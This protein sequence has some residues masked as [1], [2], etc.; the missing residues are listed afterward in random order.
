MLLFFFVFII[1]IIFIIIIVR[2][3]MESNVTEREFLEQLHE[4]NQ[5]IRLLLLLLFLLRFHYCYFST[6]SAIYKL[7]FKNYCYYLNFNIEDSH[8][9]FYLYNPHNLK[10]YC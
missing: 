8:P 5:K 3:I 1:I 4:L 7:L 9:L 6:I 10:F 2:V